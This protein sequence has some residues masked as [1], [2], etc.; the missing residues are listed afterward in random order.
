MT[1][2]AL[3]ALHA[4]AFDL[5]RGWSADEFEALLSAPGAILEATEGAFL[6][7]RV[8]HDE[9]EVLTLATDPVQRR[10]GRAAGLLRAFE[11]SARTRGATAVLL[12][13]AADNRPA[14]ALYEGH[15]YRPA[16]RRPRYYA[17]A[18]GPAV[19][20]LVLRKDLAPE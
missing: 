16:G 1:P 6:L 8:T 3:A 10:R 20:A 19:D 18:D 14:L 5:D 7:G 15:G 9:A 17:R 4:A 2:E 11:V 13:V 12:E